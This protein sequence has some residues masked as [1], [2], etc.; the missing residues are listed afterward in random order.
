MT[1]LPTAKAP[2]LDHAPAPHT[3]VFA[4]PDGRITLGDGPETTQI[5]GVSAEELASLKQ[6]L[7]ALPKPKLPAPGLLGERLINDARYLHKA[8]VQHR[9]AGRQEKADA[10]E[11][12]GAYQRQRRSVWIDGLDRCGMSVA[13]G[14]A[15]AGVGRILSGDTQRVQSWDLGTTPLRLTELGLSRATALQRQLARIHPHTTV[16]GALELSHVAHCLDAVIYIRND[17]LTTDELSQLA[18]LNIPVL[19]IVLLHD[20]ARIGPLIRTPHAGDSASPLLC[21]E[22]VTNTWPLREERTELSSPHLSAPE[23]AQTNVVAAIGVQHALHILDER[24]PPPSTNHS[25]RIDAKTSAI[26]YQPASCNCPR[27]RHAP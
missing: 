9:T 26:T 16:I 24:I 2:E 17:G 23:T 15:A 19:P 21:A 1:A 25:I 3:R 5:T 18:S 4:Y 12:P 11:L 14:L 20:H 10:E 6:L 13:F 27:Q 22:C 8:P 7:T